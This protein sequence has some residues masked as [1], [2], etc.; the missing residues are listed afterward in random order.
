MKHGVHTYTYSEE[1]G[2]RCCITEYIAYKRFSCMWGQLSRL[3][4]TPVGWRLT[5]YRRLF[6][7]RRFLEKRS[8][9]AIHKGEKHV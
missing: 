6:T 7:T 3:L 4:F 1:G 2:G 8:A 9:D 5:F